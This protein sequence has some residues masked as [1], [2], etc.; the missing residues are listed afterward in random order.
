[1]EFLGIFEVNLCS[2]CFI[3]GREILER[4]G[5]CFLETG[6]EFDVCQSANQPL[7]VYPES[8]NRAC[9]AEVPFSSTSSLF[10]SLSF[11]KIF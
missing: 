6:T 10:S 8:Q 4:K 1:M 11:Y 9:L 2:Y 5:I 3:L 7:P